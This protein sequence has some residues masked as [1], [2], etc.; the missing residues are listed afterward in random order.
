VAP[1]S[2]LYGHKLT[3]GEALG[4]PRLSEFWDVIDFVVGSDPLV[5]EHHY[6]HPYLASR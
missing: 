2:P 3:R 5:H 1:D 6:G 4:H